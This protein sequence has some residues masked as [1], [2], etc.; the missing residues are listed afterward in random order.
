MKKW[1]KIRTQESYQCGKFYRV[2]KDRVLTPGGIET[3]Y[4]VVKMK[5]TVSI[6]PMNDDGR[7]YMTLQHRYP[8]DNY[9][10]ELPSGSTEEKD[11]K[12][13]I[14]VARR[15][16]E[17][18]TGLVSSDW[19]SAGSFEEANGFSDRTCHI[20]I[21]RGVS[22]KENPDWDPLD[23]D[24]HKSVSYTYGQIEK[25]LA[26]GKIRDGLTISSFMIAEKQRLLK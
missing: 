15:E 24:L 1:K 8:T 17:E 12:D 9:F 4:Y 19:Q 10:P 26:D 21:A 5:P 6:I 18:E 25:M 20:F 13:L 7:I 16:L 23:K 14:A 22:K 11:K 3:D 2:D